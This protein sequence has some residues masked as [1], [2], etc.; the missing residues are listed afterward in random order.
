MWGFEKKSLQQQQ[1]RRSRKHQ[2]YA[3]L[4]ENFSCPLA[5]VIQRESYYY[6]DRR[7][8][9][10]RLPIILHEPSIM[11]YVLI[12]LNDSLDKSMERERK[13]GGLIKSRVRDSNEKAAFTINLSRLGGKIE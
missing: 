2:L 4:Q 9:I 5:C 8:K 13:K 1:Q 12:T 10:F 3:K 7:I 6:S 11:S